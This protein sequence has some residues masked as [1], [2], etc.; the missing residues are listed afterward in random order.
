MGMGGMGGSPIRVVASPEQRVD[1]D[2]REET[3]MDS[4]RGFQAYLEREG[5][6]SPRDAWPGGGETGLVPSPRRGSSPRRAPRVFLPLGEESLR[7]E[8]AHVPRVDLLHVDPRGGEA[9][10][11]GEEGEY[12]GEDEVGEGLDRRPD[13]AFARPR[14]RPAPV[15]RGVMDGVGFGPAAVAARTGPPVS[16]AGRKQREGNRVLEAIYGGPLAKQRGRSGRAGREPWMRMRACPMC[17]LLLSHGLSTVYCSEH[18]EE[19]AVHR[20]YE[21]LK[22][23]EKLMALVRDK[24]G[25]PA[26][27]PESEALAEV[28]AV[29]AEAARGAS[30]PPPPRRR[31]SPPRRRAS[32]GRESPPPWGVGPGAQVPPRVP[33]KLPPGTILVGARDSGEAMRGATSEGGPSGYMRTTSARLGVHHLAAR[34]DPNE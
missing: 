6:S 29:A 3:R 34:W 11:W 27:T 12:E 31:A 26:D 28:E 23:A 20:L 19:W 21:S 17:D 1:L 18:G 16:A 9:E 25:V 24:G 10:V 33:P 8:P 2:A 7:S 22:R 32:P 30:P 15:R 13:A 4:H 14:E 5:L